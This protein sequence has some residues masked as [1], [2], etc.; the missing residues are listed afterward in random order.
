MEK[1]PLSAT[2]TAYLSEAVT[3][4]PPS[5]CSRSRGASDE[6][7]CSLDNIPFAVARPVLM[8]RLNIP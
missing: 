2:S 6:I 3:P 1:P 5:L 7:S 4:P 8:F